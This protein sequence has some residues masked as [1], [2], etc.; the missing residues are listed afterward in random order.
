MVQKVGRVQAEARARVGTR[1]R[2]TVENGAGRGTINVQQR[3]WDT[4]EGKNK[5]E[6][7]TSGYNGGCDV[8]VLCMYVC[9]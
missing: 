8:Y 6:T 3:A 5:E 7:R 1:P 9:M 4:E 2:W